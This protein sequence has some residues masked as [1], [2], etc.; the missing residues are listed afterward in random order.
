MVGCAPTDPRERDRLQALARVVVAASP[1]LVPALEHDF[2]EAA[3]DPAATRAACLRWAGIAMLQQ[4]PLVDEEEAVLAQ[5]LHTDS[6]E[7]SGKAIAAV[8]RGPDES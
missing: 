4:Q 6:G 5:L 8:D 3:A 2:A 7:R 1:R